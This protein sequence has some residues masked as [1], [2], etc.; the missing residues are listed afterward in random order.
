MDYSYR[1]L[2]SIQQLLRKIKLLRAEMLLNI[3]LQ[4]PTKVIGIFIKNFTNAVKKLFRL[5]MIN[6]L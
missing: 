3:I 2:C 6:Y 4:T 5:V 1:I